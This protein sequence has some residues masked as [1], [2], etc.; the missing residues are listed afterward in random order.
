MKRL[1]NKYTF[2]ILYALLL[3]GMAV[4]IAW[5]LSVSFTDAAVSVLIAD[6]SKKVIED[7]EKEE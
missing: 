3:C 1:L 4:V 6:H 5:I 7:W 2:T